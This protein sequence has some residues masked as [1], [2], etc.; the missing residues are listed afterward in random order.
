MGHVV[1]LSYISGWVWSRGMVQTGIDGELLLA[2]EP[3]RKILSYC[4]KHLFWMKLK[5]KLSYWKK[6]YKQEKTACFHKRF[7]GRYR[8]RTYDLPH[9]KRML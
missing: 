9:V 7:G 8:T 5:I 6:C 4:R 1:F 2:N 3:G